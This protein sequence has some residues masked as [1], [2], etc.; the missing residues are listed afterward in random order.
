MPYIVQPNDKLIVLSSTLLNGPQA[1]VGVAQYNG[2]KNPNAI[3]VGQKLD[4]P[5][6][7][8]AAKPS[9]GSI[10]SVSGDVTVGGQPATAGT[11]VKEGHQFKLGANSST[12]IEL[13]DGSRIKLLPNTLA[14]VVS[15]RHYPVRDTSTSGTTNWF[16]GLMRLT[17]GSL[18][19]AASKMTQRATPLK[20][21][22]PTSVVGVRGTM[23]RVA[24]D[25]S[26]SQSARTEVLEGRVRAD[27]PAQ[28]AGAD[29]PMGT[30]AVIKPSDRE[31]K[32]VNLLPAPDLTTMATDVFQP[33]GQLNLPT[34]A[35]SA[36]YRVVI[37]RDEQFNNIAREAIVP[38][39]TPASL[40]GLGNGSF[41]A[42]VRGID[43]IGLE[44]FN[45]VKRIV[46]LDAPP[47]SGEPVLD[48]WRGNGN[49]LISL[50][51]EGSN[52][53]ISWSEA[54]GTKTAGMR[55]AAEIGSD[56]S[57][58]NSTTTPET[59]Q[60]SVNLGALKPGTYFIRLRF[61]PAVGAPL[62]GSIYRFTLSDNWNKTVFRTM[63]SLQ[64]AV[65]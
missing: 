47:P 65:P 50:T 64:I 57:L 45:S 39:G 37:A 13:G 34:L 41:Y 35:G 3:S 62:Q 23:F 46:L 32:A 21:E 28:A 48:P 51:A 14:E 20:I 33:L 27:N 4:I 44:G 59:T 5:L 55:Y 9:A 36:S 31:V 1:W 29:L 53:L 60:R 26:N 42:L 17:Q 30:G 54:A 49:T 11:A 63:S 16:S 58:S 19:A 40:A 18:E 61:S 8:L 38:A 24:F 56:A 22:T 15:N 7:Y 52:T 2:L 6:R 10:I 43:G 25:Q 12:V